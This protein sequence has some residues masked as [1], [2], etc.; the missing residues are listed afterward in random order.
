[1][2]IL[3]YCVFSA[4]LSLPE[5]VT[6]VQEAPIQRLEAD[7]LAALYSEAAVLSQDPGELAQAAM[8]FQSTVQQV[9]GAGIVI[10]FRF[11]TLL[12]SVSELQK[13]LSENGSRY[14]TALKLLNGMAQMEVRL[15]R[16]G[17]GPSKENATTGTEYLKAR[18]AEAN[19]MI[20]AVEALKQSAGPL[21]HE[22]RSRENAGVTRF[23]A[24]IPHDKAAEFKR[25]MGFVRL[26]GGIRAVISGPWPPSE[27][28]PEPS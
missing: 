23:Y 3:P 6:G 15:T 17:S 9:F 19:E 10:G 20:S 4:S 11:P 21:V 8:T 24:L 22:W 1:M 5:I 27:F 26:S 12:D 14:R 18:Q 16:L 7:D 2:P 13:H 28:L 25:L